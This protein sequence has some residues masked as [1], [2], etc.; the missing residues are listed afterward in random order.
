MRRANRR[1]QQ[2][3]QQAVVQVAVAPPSKPRILATRTRLVMAA[4]TA[5]SGN[6]NAT[7]PP[8]SFGRQRLGALL[9]PKAEVLTL[10]A[11]AGTRGGTNAKTQI[12]VRWVRAQPHLPMSAGNGRNPHSRAI[13]KWSRCAVEFFLRSEPWLKVRRCQRI[14][15]SRTSKTLTLATRHRSAPAGAP[16]FSGS[17]F[18]NTESPAARDFGSAGR[19]SSPRLGGPLNACMVA[20]PSVAAGPSA[21]TSA[22]VSTTPGMGVNNMAATVGTAATAGTAAV[23]VA[24]GVVAGAGA[25]DAG[26]AASV[27]A[28]DGAGVSVGAVGGDL[29]GAGVGD[30]RDISA[31]TLGGAGPYWG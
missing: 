21:G 18:G 15:R 26:A 10:G 20:R 8:S 12:R 1:L 27:G 22:R 7:A 13:R 6:R 31:T 14:A 17:R 5:A 25:A 11:G 4:T 30:G 16:G 23:G 9:W 24:G 2:A 3:Q 29:A 19:M 28:G